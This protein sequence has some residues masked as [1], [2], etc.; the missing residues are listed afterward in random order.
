MGQS[1]SNRAN[2]PRCILFVAGAFPSTT[3]ITR[4]LVGLAA[5]G[6][7][8]T[9]MARQRGKW[10]A[11]DGVLPLPPTLEVKDLIPDYGFRQPRRALRL[12]AHGPLHILRRPKRALRLWRMCREASSSRGQAVRLFI[13]HLAF[14]SLPRPDIIQFEFLV[15]ATLYPVLGKLLNC[16]TLLSCRGA[17]LHMLEVRP[18]VERQRR[19]YAIHTATAVH[20]V[21]NELA[22]EVSRIAGR[23]AGV[24]VNRPAVPVDHI[25]PRQEH[26]A[27]GPPLILSVGRLEWKKGYDYL[28]AA[29]ARLRQAGVA[30][31]ARLIGGGSLYSRLR[32]SID[33]MGLSDCVVLTG[34]LPFSGV[35]AALHEADIFVLSSHEEGIANAV[36]EAM[37]AGLPIV[38]TNAGG[39][40]EAVRD[41][42]EGFVVPV[43]DIEALAG[44][45]QQLVNDAELRRRMGRAARVRC[46]AD[47]SLARQL[48]GFERI[49]RDMLGD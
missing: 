21:S 49:Y 6:H 26:S 38:T 3:F 14:L 17:D 41:G 2:A 22:S 15:T 29:L 28:L 31:N 1:P 18:E 25:S 46:E 32:F 20:C 35:L 23:Q 9:V 12:L 36:L 47:F 8:V 24:S 39:M 48:D 42:V 5:R 44:R 19:I 30:F 13:R 33:D 4:M 7:H 11:D 43:R 27:S 40:P 34:R 45:I 10:D 37:A 16:P